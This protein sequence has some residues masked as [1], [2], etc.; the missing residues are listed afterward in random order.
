MLSEEG[1]AELQKEI[2]QMGSA[3]LPQ[4]MKMIREKESR[5]KR[6]VYEFAAT[7]GLTELEE[8]LAPIIQDAVDLDRR[9][10]CAA[11]AF[12]MLGTNANPVV[13]QLAK[14][15]DD[16]DLCFAV[17]RALAGIGPEA[18]PV[19]LSRADSKNVVI[20]RSVI[21]AMELCGE[22]SEIVIPVLI[23]ACN[24]TNAEARAAAISSLGRI[25]KEPVRVVPLLVQALT[26][27]NSDVRTEAAQA[28][29]EFGADAEPSVPALMLKTR[30]LETY[31]RANA[32]ASLGRIRKRAEL[33]VPALAA[34]LG[35]PE[36]DVRLLATTA[37]G[38]FGA[39]AESAVPDLLL[40][41]SRD[42][43]KSIHGCAA[44]SLGSIC[45]CP[46]IVVPALMACLEHE[47]HW[48]RYSAASALVE[49]GIDAA[50]AVGSMLVSMTQTD[51]SPRRGIIGALGDLRQSPELVVTALLMQLD[52][53][54]SF[55]RA[56]AAAAL[57]NFGSE[58]EMAIPKLVALLNDPEPDVYNAVVAAIQA[59][60][61]EAEVLR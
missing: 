9:R 58:A 44:R 23:R 4:L 34:C 52:N 3:A 41:L 15:I 8:R 42:E 40:V 39:D 55:I 59:I 6:W 54:Y 10:W 1:Y 2:Q 35:D 33:A 14:L 50:C 11:E 30:D 29:G 32:A 13:P 43:D 5:P 20:R 46:E 17:P 49:F 19:L 28:L 31:V 45:K 18:L 47:D 22:Q 12:V 24:D 57:G 27:Q 48:I 37:L 61:P 51:E 26:S 38:E 7:H 60:D 25:H 21:R 16:E 56:D 36:R 53:E